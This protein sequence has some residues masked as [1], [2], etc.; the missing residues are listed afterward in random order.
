MLSE[1]NIMTPE[2]LVKGVKISD[3]VTLKVSKDYLRAYLILEDDQEPSLEVLKSISDTLDN[4][5]IIYGKLLTPEPTEDGWLIAKGK[6]PI[7]GKDGRIDLWVELPQKQTIKG[8]CED[9][10]INVSPL[11]EDS[12]F[13][14]THCIEN[15]VNV[16]KGQVIAQKIPPTQGKAGRDIFGNTIPAPYGKYIAFKPGEGVE[17]SKDGSKLLASIDGR[18]E[19]KEDGTISVFDYWTIDGSVDAR[20]GHINFIGKTLTINGSIE[21]GFKVK[22]KG[23]LTVKGSI[24]NGAHVEANGNI[25]VNGLIRAN[26]TFVYTKRDL[27]CLAIEYARVKV[28]GNLVVK[29]YILDARCHVR[30]N[31]EVIKGRGQVL[32]G[33]VMAGRSIVLDKVGSVANVRTRV[34]AGYDPLIAIKYHKIVNNIEILSRKKRQLTEGL[35]KILAF[36]QT[37]KLNKNLRHKKDMIQNALL[38]IKKQIVHYKRELKE[39]EIFFSNLKEATILVKSYIRTNTILKIEN[40]TLK[41]SEDLKG[42]ILFYFSQGDIS[43]KS[44]KEN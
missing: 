21:T 34:F 14:E 22:T 4:A 40:A 41:L 8:S 5:G 23:D 38:D 7:A 11:D 16:E 32:G 24:E 30:K 29:D 33:S 35:K 9:F 6:E 36:Q 2:E 31:I 39:M 1:D 42:P 43:F 17:I 26:K 13:Q 20:I 15:I 18:L 44:L 19:V 27:S 37:N 28:E 10:G 3:K 12:E 25:V